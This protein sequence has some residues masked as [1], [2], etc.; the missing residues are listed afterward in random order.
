MNFKLLIIFCIFQNTYTFSQEVL[1]KGNVFFNAKNQSK[2]LRPLLLNNTDSQK[3]TNSILYLKLFKNTLTKEI[4][5]Q[6][7]IIENYQFKFHI[8]IAE[9]TYAEI[10]YYDQILKLYL[11]PFDTIVVNIDNYHYT[12]DEKLNSK[13]ALYNNLLLE[14]IANCIPSADS[15][16]NICKQ[17]PVDIAI[18]YKEYQLTTQEKIL[19]DSDVKINNNYKQFLSST[20]DARYLL[21]ILPIYINL[22]NKIPKESLIKNIFPKMNSVLDSFLSKQENLNSPYFERI[23]KIVLQHHIKDTLINLDQLKS[24]LTNS[25]E[26]KNTENIINYYL[27]NYIY[28]HTIK[29]KTE[30]I[31]NITKYNKINDYFQ[32]KY[33]IGKISNELLKLNTKTSNN[34]LIS[35]E[36]LVESQSN[37]YSYF[38]IFPNVE[39]LD[40]FYTQIKYNLKNCKK[41]TYYII[42]NEKY[43]FKKINAI[44]YLTAFDNKKKY[45]KNQN[46]PIC[47]IISNTDK[48]VI[49]NSAPLIYENDFIY[50]MDYI[51]Q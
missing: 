35:I 17:L 48:T 41:I 33:S 6:I 7:P 26:I 38:L 27:I 43:N 11:N 1:I 44:N 30:N 14:K 20:I 15:T 32:K 9:P 21:D 34:L 8:K 2:T 5:Y 12:F 51:L 49:S 10:Y 28:K 45:D 50:Q 24:F 25:Y 29:N 37:G 46:L 18:A 47:L 22:Q 40:Y 19:Y 4:D 31:A 36:D 23:A 13:T 16:S 42:T 3:Y 39:L